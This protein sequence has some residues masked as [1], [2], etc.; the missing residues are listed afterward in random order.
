MG[1]KKN[2]IPDAM[3]RLMAP[4]DRAQVVRPTCGAVPS[5]PCPCAAKDS[6]TEK[7]L[8]AHIANLLNQRCIFHLRSRMDKKTTLPCGM[9]DFFIF[10]PSGRFLAVE[11]KVEGGRL[12]DDQKRVFDRFW[13]YTGHVVHIV[14]TFQQFVELL[15][16]H[17]P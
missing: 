11:C 2:Q 7:E 12:S 14:W 15:N 3:F 13:A 9:P 17:N 4:E 1:L 16:Q 6:P 8:Q 10:L 5:T